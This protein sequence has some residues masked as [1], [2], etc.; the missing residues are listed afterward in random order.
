M[1]S[2]GVEKHEARLPVTWETRSRFGV[3]FEDPNYQV[4]LKLT[5]AMSRQMPPS[6]A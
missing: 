1:R 4:A 5:D 3:G 2:W 6:T